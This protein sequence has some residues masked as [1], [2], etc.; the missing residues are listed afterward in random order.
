[1]PTN[2]Y[3]SFD[4]KSTSL[5]GKNLV[6]ASA[7]TGKTYSIAILVLRMIIEA[8]IDVSKQLIVTF[9]NFAVAELQ[10]RIRLFLKQGYDIVN[11]NEAED[12]VF[13]TKDD[14]II[15][16]ICLKA[17][18]S[19]P[20]VK[21]TLRAALLTIDEASILTIH[22]FCQQMLK[23]FAFETQQNF[24]ATL[25][26]DVSV[27]I[28]E[29]ANEFWRKELSLLPVGL[30]EVYELVEIKTNLQYLLKQK[31]AKTS[32]KLSEE[33]N[34][35]DYLKTSIN[36]LLAQ[37]EKKSHQ[38]EAIVAL[39]ENERDAIAE[40]IKTSHHAKKKYEPLMQ[41]PEA[42]LAAAN[43]AFTDKKGL[44]GYYSK[45]TSIIW[46]ELQNYVQ[47]DEEINSLKNQVKSALYK[48]GLDSY[49]TQLES[50]IQEAGILTFDALILK[51]HEAIVIKNN[52]NLRK[53]IRAK[54]PVVFIDEFQDTDSIQFQL[55]DKLF[56]AEDKDDE[57]ATRLFLIGD[58]K[59]SIY[60][61]RNADVES[62]LTAAYKV[63]NKYS[64][65]T[66][67]RSTTEMV[68]AAN[69]F[70]EASGAEVFGYKE[71]D[72]AKISYQSVIAQDKTKKMLHHGK[73]VTESIL[74]CSNTNLEMSTDDLCHTVAYLL[75][76]EN[77]FEIYDGKS[78]RPIGTQD[79]AVLT[80][81][82][83]D[84]NA[85]KIKLHKQN[86][87]AVNIDEQ[88]VL[89]SIEARDLSLILKAMLA[90]SIPNV[91]AALYLTFLNHI[92]QH[93]FYEW[94]PL[95]AINEI[96]ALALFNSYHKIISQGTVYQ[97]LSKMMSDFSVQQI[98][99]ETYATRRTLANILQLAE[100]AHQQQYKKG[101]TAAELAAWLKKARSND[102]M[103][104]DEYLMQIES[105]AKAV[106]IL[107]IHKSKGLEFP[108]VLT[109][110]LNR[111]ATIKKRDFY[112]VKNKEGYKEIIPQES[113]TEAMEAGL[114]SANDQENRRL[115]YVAVT[116]AVYQCYL[117]YSVGKS[118]TPA[119]SVALNSLLAPLS[120]GNGISMDF[121]P[122]SDQSNFTWEKA[123]PI[124]PINQL[125]E[126]L[127]EESRSQWALLSFSS[128][129]IEH[130]YEPKPAQ[131]KEES[132]NNFVFNQL[133]RGAAA[134]TKLHELFE[135]IDFTKDFT[136]TSA[137][138][139][140]EKRQLDLFN[141]KDGKNTIDF[142]P[143]VA[144][145]IHHVLHA[146]I[147]VDGCKI[148]LHSLERHQKLHELEFEF[149][150]S[151]HQ[152]ST[153]V[154]PLLAKYN[155]GIQARYHQLEGMMTGFI[156]LLFEYEDKYYILDWKSNY[157]GF[158]LEDYTGEGLHQAMQHNHY[159]L[160]YLIYTLAVHKYLRQRM[161]NNYRYEEHFG[162]VI[163]VF[164]RG[165]RANKSSGIFTEKPPIAFIEQ[166][167]HALNEQLAI[168]N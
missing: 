49:S 48:L 46:K 23:S 123:L 26:N 155:T 62:Y 94:I 82:K 97:A 108:I 113:L 51:L 98:L 92:H 111:D 117:F 70:F 104:G 91:K 41:Q 22:G 139:G 122:P 165:A 145:M 28:N 18:A 71:E 124:T 110:G 35:A 72:T 38:F 153:L 161:G 148:Q 140:Y 15:R 53:L 66:N 112:E 2:N 168:T 126:H 31:L 158:A 136:N 36:N 80:N 85:I 39:F 107:T 142:S 56:I 67:F 105:D 157:L 54:Y 125:N 55:F 47:Y 131:A 9:T 121:R 116:R 79:I 16:E 29:I 81:S 42:F 34:H 25:Q 147:E 120:S 119:P 6:E 60:A 146:Q 20:Q 109:F 77:G 19:D 43:G 58:P 133:P 76:P 11:R 7:G 156:D 137:I 37:Q 75:N 103:I 93:T 13:C 86:I 69:C 95:H 128:L 102:T 135:R 115:I 118:K 132:Y 138:G 8:N 17:K 127:L 166:L 130:E 159:T 57:I 134:G 40:D 84:G 59:Q 32:F 74:V 14:P 52:L 68:N 141:K 61:F 12:A 162:G 83:K 73:P 99:S 163:Y 149:P 45:F 33:F 151:Q 106:N 154:L 129:A 3:L 65:S 150:I 63:D 100:L 167:E 90:P 160:Q 21:D 78:K 1:M 164:L 88:T 96:E 4:V 87:P 10:E 152:V 144:Q 44:P 30:F 5:T 27:F 143:M 24:E 101:W 114:M 50:A 64:M 89:H